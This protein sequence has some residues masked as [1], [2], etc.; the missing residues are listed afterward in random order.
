METRIGII[1]TR[2]EFV[3]H[4]HVSFL[5]QDNNCKSEAVSIPAVK[6]VFGQCFQEENNSNIRVRTRVVNAAL[7]FEV[8]FTTS[9]EVEL[10]SKPKNKVNYLWRA[11]T[12]NVWEVVAYFPM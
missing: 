5:G 3:C 4:V 8:N 11:A 6:S 9:G 12:N 1:S 2:P 10:K 7:A